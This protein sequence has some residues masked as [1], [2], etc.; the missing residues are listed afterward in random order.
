MLQ[1]VVVVVG[2]GGM[3]T[4]GVHDVRACSLLSGICRVTWSKVTKKFGLSS[5]AWL[6]CGWS[7]TPVQS[8]KG[9]VIPEMTRDVAKLDEAMKLI[10]CG[11]VRNY[12]DESL[13][14]SFHMLKINVFQVEWWSKLQITMI[15][16]MHWQL[17]YCSVFVHLNIISSF[18]TANF[19]NWTVHPWL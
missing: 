16:W 4:S 18:Q 15:R 13:R 14:H 6:F 8:F 17:I 7:S 12:S 5:T 1:E 3:V 9:H 2:L 10:K 11:L 19:C